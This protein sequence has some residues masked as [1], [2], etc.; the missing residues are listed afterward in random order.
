MDH[1]RKNCRYKVWDR[2]GV[3]EWVLFIYLVYVNICNNLHAP[4][5][6]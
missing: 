1:T 3:V 5:A 6:K 2:V 4:T